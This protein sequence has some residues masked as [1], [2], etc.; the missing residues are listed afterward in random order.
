MM[1]TAT[2]EVQ[3]K[4][5]RNVIGSC[6][7]QYLQSL[8]KTVREISMFSDTCGGQNRNQNIASVLLYVVQSID[9]INVI[10]QKFLEKGHRHG[11]QLHAFSHRICSKEQFCTLCIG[12]L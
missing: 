8:P 11:M 10:K 7:L 5:C 3:G 6:M 9:H 1:A 2:T 4:W 12:L